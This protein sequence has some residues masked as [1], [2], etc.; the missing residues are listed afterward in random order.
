MIVE[1]DKLLGDL[2]SRIL[3][4]EGCV[5]KNIE[6]GE[7]VLAA[8]EAERPDLIYLDLLLPMMSGFDVLAGLKK[9]A[10]TKDIPV[11][12]IS[13][14]GERSDIRRG[15]DLGADGY[16]VKATVTT[17]AIIAEGVKILR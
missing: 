6:S 17:D 8:A 9:S 15:Y 3:T 12:I 2:L 13:C 11:I 1:D 10:K 16:L 4:S 7:L 5:V 14:L